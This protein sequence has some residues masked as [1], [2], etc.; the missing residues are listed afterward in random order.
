MNAG[1]T[2]RG[3]GFLVLLASLPVASASAASGLDGAERL[4]LRSVVL[5]EE[6]TLAVVTPA[7]YARGQ[8]RYPVLYLT[9]AEAQI[10]HLRATA[11]FLARN[12]LVPDMIVVGIVNTA[13]TRDLTPTRGSAE[14]RG[15]FPGGGGGERFLDFVEKEVVPA[16]DARYRTVPL[17]VL[18]GHSFGGLLAVHALFN[19]PELFQAVIAA[20]PSLGW[21]DKLPL[22]D[23]RLAR[24]GEATPRALYVSLGERESSPAG[25][26]LFEDFARAAHGVPWK[27]FRY[28]WQVIPDEDHGSVVLRSYYA[29]LRHVFAGWRFPRP[30]AA[31]PPPTLAAVREHYRAL[32]ERW[33]ITIPPP[34]GLVNVVGYA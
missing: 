3:L 31:A 2:M 24:A 9:D 32:S 23:V 16:I 21:D 8:L 34:E 5:D 28:E 26:E 7:S 20:S 33:R 10:G 6:R 4:T 13:R 11:E 29:G 15:A 19:R 18:A 12:G 30:A 14:E 17:R 1:V 25:L 22:R 27:D